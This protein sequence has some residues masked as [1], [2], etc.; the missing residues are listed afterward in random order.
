MRFARLMVLAPFPYNG[1][2]R[3]ELSKLAK[4]GQM[5]TDAWSGEFPA[6]AKAGQPGAGGAGG[7]VR[8]K[9]RSVIIDFREAHR[10]N[11]VL[12]TLANRPDRAFGPVAPPWRRRGICPTFGTRS[13]F[14]TCMRNRH[15][16]WIPADDAF[17]IWTTVVYDRR[18]NLLLQLTCARRAC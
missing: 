16:F 7:A 18:Y 17:V 4:S 11:K 8:S 2:H 14:V 5:K 3:P 12:T 6:L 1:G 13:A 10:I 9:S 15:T